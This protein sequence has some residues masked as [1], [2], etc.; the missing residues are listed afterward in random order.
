M[1]L[2]RNLFSHIN[3]NDNF[4]NNHNCSSSMAKNVATDY[5]FQLIT[6][7]ISVVKTPYPPVLQTRRK[8]Y[9]YRESLSI[10]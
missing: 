10:M 5:S 8:Q 4:P 1:T 3:S 9:R 2:Q 7:N 6:E